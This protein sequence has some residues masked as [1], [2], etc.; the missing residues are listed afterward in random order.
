MR[1]VSVMTAAG[2]GMAW[3]SESC[4][5]DAHA[6]EA[7]G[8]LP[9]PGTLLATFPAAAITLFRICPPEYPAREPAMPPPI[10]ADALRICEAAARAGG[11]VLLDW[12]GRFGVSNK[13][14]RDL[15][16]EADFASQREIRQ[17]VLGAFPD[18]GFI[19]EESLPEHAAD[20]QPGGQSGGQQAAGGPPLRWMVDPLDGTS[21]YVHGFPAWCVSIALARGD[22]IL[23]G[24]VYDP[25]RDE[26]FTAQLGA[27][28]RL[29]GKPI[30]VSGCVLLSD[31]LV[32]LSF[33][34]HV[35]TESV[36]VADFLAVVP[37]VHSAR[38]T[39]S[40]ALNLAWLACGRLDAFWVRRIA[41]W[42]VAAGL[43][44]F[45]EAGGCLSGFSEGPAAL[46][47]VSLDQPSF[48]AACTLEVLAE[49][50]MRLG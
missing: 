50:R 12:V 23:V 10:P 7:S 37:H 6:D 28:A 13:G 34:P 30:R 33:P 35:S 47:W 40:T 11:R 49:L 16:T 48:V 1:A 36:A 26:C 38:R 8:I 15:V 5:A 41:C 29:N 2:Q 46:E 17:I 25:V 45:R 22:E 42:D 21:N 43:L 32:A 44:I 39:G 31:A 24:T 9:A 27:G 19:G 4:D 20:G 14:P 3:R 18:H